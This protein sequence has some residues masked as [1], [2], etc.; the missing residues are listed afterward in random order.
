MADVA[1]DLKTWS[2]TAAS[3]SPAGGTAVG[4]G[5][6]DNLRELQKVVRQ[7]LATKGSDVASATSTDIGAVAGFMHDITGTTT[8]TG[9]GTVSSGI[10]KVIKFEDA[11]TL[12]H[13]ATSLILP[14][15][16]SITTADGDIG[17]FISEG[18]G[19][20]RCIHY[21]RASGKPVTQ[22][23]LGT[24]QASTSGTAID[25]TS[26]PSWVKKI[27]IMLVGVSTSGTSNPLIQIGDSGGIEN[28]G[29]L[30]SSAS[31]ASG[32][33]TTGDTY[34]TGF[35]IAGAQAT[36]VM[37]GTITLNLE[38]SA[39]NT[40]VCSHVIGYSNTAAASVGGGSKSLSATLDRVR[41]TTE[42]GTDTF[43]A[44]DINIQYE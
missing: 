42:G 24:E 16:T 25:F 33:A 21:T 2:A 31:P 36:N 4:T 23:T 22:I 18:S 11:L 35:G 13:N 43:D 15:G 34:T 7:D 37:H 41:I 28:T 19:N 6:D 38:D 32:G 9:L 44:G 39:N 26:I 10:H 40:W 27:T 17:W 29:Y 5:L 20:W 3:N 1:G 30:G 14:G 12:T 8:I